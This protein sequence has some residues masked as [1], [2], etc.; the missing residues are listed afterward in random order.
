MFLSYSTPHL[1]VVTYQLV[2]SF[3][4][5]CTLKFGDDCAVNFNC[6]WCLSRVV[7]SFV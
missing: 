6:T 4:S 5:D 1:S 2:T 3:V 7:G